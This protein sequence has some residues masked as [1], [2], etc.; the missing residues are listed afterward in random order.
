VRSGLELVPVATR[1]V[2]VGRQPIVDTS[3]ALVGYE[4]LYRAAGVGHTAVTGEQMTAEVLFGTLTIGVDQ[5]VGDRLAFCN[6]DRGVLLG[7]TPVTLPPDRTVV[8]VLETVVIDADVVRGCQELVQRGFQI[9]LDDFVWTDGVEQLLELASIVKIDVLAMSREEVVELVDRC[10]AYDVLLLA[11]K[12]ETAE[13]LA[14]AT[15]IGFHLFQGYVIERPAQ[16]RGHALPAAAAAHVQL[17]VHVLADE[18]DFREIEEI[19]R[20]EPGLVVQLLQMAGRGGN[21]GLR[22][23]VRTIRDALVLLGT[24]RVRQWIGLTLLQGQ[25]SSNPDAVITALARA[26]ACEL[27]ARQL[28]GASGEAAFTAGLVSALDVLLGVDAHELIAALDLDP[29]L[30]RVAFERVGEAGALVARVANFQEDVA[31][32]RSE[33][34]GAA[35][36]PVLAEAVA[37]AFVWAAPQA[38]ALDAA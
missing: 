25:R 19:L 36:D 16:V 24:A 27:L 21:Q 12:V 20:R 22:R 2:V 13:Q 3:G 7:E 28:T 10:R 23:E 33:P 8:E 29:D 6:A 11:E 5:L 30:K 9:A 34:H 1:E 31:R 35:T 32:G 4:L 37:A 26:R 18:L 15:Q 14:W 38:N 17:A